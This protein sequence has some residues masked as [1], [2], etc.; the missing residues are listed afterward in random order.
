MST[1][2]IPSTKYKELKTKADAYEQIARFFEASFFSSPP[3][4]SASKII[5]EFKKTKKYNSKFLKSL[6]KGLVRS[7]YFKE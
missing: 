4:K 3:K 1:V 5:G 2:T 7:L 6:E